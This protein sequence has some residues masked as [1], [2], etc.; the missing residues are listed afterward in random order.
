MFACFSEVLSPPFVTKY[1]HVPLSM[2]QLRHKKHALYIQQ[3]LT[4][5]HSRHR[6]PRQ[7]RRICR[8]MVQAT[9]AHLQIHAAEGQWVTRANKPL[10]NKGKMLSKRLLEAQPIEGPPP[11]QSIHV[12]LY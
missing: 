5:P 10:K 9:A 11:P 2:L 6:L 3:S 7:D 8:Q 12:C 1:V 4:H